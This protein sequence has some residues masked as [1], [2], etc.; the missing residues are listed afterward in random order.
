[1]AAAMSQRVGSAKA[2]GDGA[3]YAG[4]DRRSG[5]SADTT[6]GRPFA[7]AVLALM[8]TIGLGGL[9]ATS[10][11]VD[12]RD[13]AILATV[14]ATA[15]ATTSLVAGVLCLS[16]Y[17]LSRQRAVLD[18]GIILLLV[19]IGWVLPATIGPLLT[20]SW[21]G[22]LDAL[23]L[24]AAVAVVAASVSIAARPQVDRRLELFRRLA[25]LLALDLAVAVA[26][27]SALDR[28]DPVVGLAGLLA[29]LGGLAAGVAALVLL[30]TGYR[31]RS[32]L[33]MF[34]GLNLIGVQMFQ[35]STGATL[36]D[37]SWR[38]G[39]SVVALVAAMIGLAGSVTDYR[40]SF[41]S[42]QTRLFESWI[43]RQ[44]SHRRQADQRAMEEERFHDLRSGLLSVE[45]F[46]RTVDLE[47]SGDVVLSELGR[48][49]ALVS[50]PVQHPELFDLVAPVRAMAAARPQHRIVVDAPA[51]LPVVAR[52]AELLECIQ[53]LVDNAIRHAPGSLVE[54]QLDGGHPTVGIVVAD[55]GP[56]IPADQIPRLFERGYTTHPDG[57]GL[58]LY[59]VAN[60][61]DSLGGT[62]EVRPRGRGV[63]FVLRA[64]IG[65]KN[66]TLRELQ[67]A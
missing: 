42:Q 33:L 56:G 30:V 25:G 17:S 58:G 53:N 49:R 26:A 19:G 54:I 28:F 64:D 36:G 46:L 8:S 62:V 57:S 34:V 65:A 23:A 1:M 29:V 11:V 5:A 52:R 32:C 10:P 15:A 16:R 24:G 60:V 6:L 22:Q 20:A 14:A 38:L 67:D 31:R 21:S 40:L 2:T 63:A 48:L 4:P 39:G 12:T 27:L 50:E 66:H 9:L 7:L 45:A 61:I 13:Q 51:C 41:R 55:R 59:I 3:Y 44:V 43:D 35:S 18:S 37:G 47:T